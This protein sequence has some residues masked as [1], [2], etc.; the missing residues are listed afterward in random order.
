MGSQSAL[1]RGSKG[2]RKRDGEGEGRTIRSLPGLGPVIWELCLSPAGLGVCSPASDSPWLERREMQT[3]WLC[4]LST[5]LD[6]VSPG[7][8]GQIAEEGLSHDLQ[9]HNP[10][11]Q[12]MGASVSNPRDSTP[13]IHKKASRTVLN[14]E[15]IRRLKKKKNE[16]KQKKHS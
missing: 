12:G 1:G 4:P 8:Q 15:V 9:Q 10:K 7:T 5:W 2:W 16:T 11:K 14:Q 3:P 13:S 6:E